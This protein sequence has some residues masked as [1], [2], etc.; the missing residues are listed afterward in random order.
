MGKTAFALN[1]AENVAVR[2]N[3]PV[4]IFSLEMSKESLLLR[5]LSADAQIDS[6]KFRTGHLNQEDKGENSA[7]ARP[8]CPKRRSG[9]TTRAPQRSWKWARN[10]AA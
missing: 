2:G 8:T 6:H 7:F 10:C 5:L 3:K 4:A 9:L 1:I